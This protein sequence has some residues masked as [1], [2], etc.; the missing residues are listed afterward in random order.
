[1]PDWTS[2]PLSTL[3]LVG[4]AGILIGVLKEAREAWRQDR[5]WFGWDLRR[6]RRHP[7]DPDPPS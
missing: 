7:G 1:M 2:D 4:G 3:L 6:L 5:P